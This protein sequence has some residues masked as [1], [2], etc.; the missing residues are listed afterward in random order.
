MKPSWIAPR[1]SF[2]LV[3]CLLAL[4]A[5]LAA[6]GGA[7][8]SS[9]AKPAG[10]LVVGKGGPHPTAPA[11][12]AEASEDDALIPISTDD[13]VR[14][15]RLAYVTIVVFSDFQCPFCTRLET[16]LDRVREEYGSDNVRIVFKNNPLPFHE[17]A[18]L[19]AEV[20]QGVLALAGPEA[21]WRYHATAFRRQ[22]VMSPEAIRAWGVAAGADERALEEGLAKKRWAQKVD[23]DVSVAKRLNANGT[24]MSF[25]NGVSL[26]GAQAFE[27]FKEIVDAELEKAKSLV[28]RG[29]PRDKVY[30]RLVAAN[31]K[32]SRGDD[33]DDDDDDS[34]AV[35]Q[36]KIVHKIPVGSAPARGPATAL[37]TIVEFSDFQCPFCKRVEESLA[38]VRREYGDKVRVVW[39]DMPLPFHPRAEPAAQLARA[40]RAQKGDAA[41][42]T[43]HDLLFD[44]QQTLE[45]SDLE[46]I[47]R[48]AKL[49]AAKAMASVKAKAFKKGIEED[50]DLGD[51][52]KAAGTPHFFINGRRLVGAQPFDKFKSVIDDEIARAEALLKQGTPRAALYD[53]LIKDGTAAAEPEKKGIAPAA[54]GAPFRGAANAKVVIQEVSDFQCPF[55]KRAEATMEE[56]LKAYPGK[57]KIVWRDKPLPMHPRAP[58]AAEAAREA[59]AQKGNDGFTKMQKLLFDNQ[60]ALER[61]DLDGYAKSIGLDMKRFAKAL[62]G[63][64]HK[65]AVDAD[66]KASTEA[67]V[68]GT[69]A[70]F[71]G[72][73][74]VSGAQPFN[75]FRKLVDRVLREPAGAAPLPA[76][77]PAAPSTSLG[78]KDVTVGS[79]RA[80]K[81][82]DTVKVHYVG[83]LADGT[84]FDQSRKRGQPFSFTVG[85]GTVIKGWEQG[86]VGMKVGGKRKLTIPSDLAYG[87]RGVGTIPPKSTLF[88]EIDLVSID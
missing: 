8:K 49:D 83:T 18:R 14:G 21:F 68:S 82:G 33:D 70:F 27:R 29:A 23:F 6:C 55:C 73:Y 39:R 80:V 63:R 13:A 66:E 16:T 43:V 71:V 69:P 54:A 47:A 67:G 12:S 22:S 74:F 10:D 86:L 87:D 42:W 24:P 9:L 2:P 76:A 60:Q 5:A 41:F 45:D 37:V 44:N 3:V 40:A 53:A 65:A 15:S 77:A 62:D 11:A 75:K 31:F 57:I 85:N 52:F 36:A 38:R 28:E 26:S 20:G 84:E 51:D 72:P 58:L 1:P 50:V 4:L 48:E 35:A 79:G 17:H 56:L 32:P 30:T 46:R 34:A 25:I 61:S 19:A 78:I 88:F 64:I 7:P 59:H 81:T